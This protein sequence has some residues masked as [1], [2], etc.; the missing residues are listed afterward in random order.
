MAALNEI[1]ALILALMAAALVADFLQV[2][3]WLALVVV[4]LV[5]LGWHFLQVLRLIYWLR[6]PKKNAPPLSIGLWQGINA[7][8]RGWRRRNRKR[9]RKLNRLLDQAEQSFKAIADMTIIV[10]KHASIEWLNEAAASFADTTITASLGQPFEQ[11]FGHYPEL[12]AFFKLGDYREV[13]RVD[14]S[15]GYV[16][17]IEIR[18]ILYGDGK[19]LINAHDVSHLHQLETVRQD[20]VANVSHELRTPLTVLSGYLEAMNESDAFTQSEWKP[21]IETMHSQ[22][23]R[24][25]R[26]VE[27]LLVLAR[28][29]NV[30]TDEDL[31]Q[32]KVIDIEKILEPI[33]IQARHLS[34]SAEHD[35]QARY[36]GSTELVSLATEM[37]VVM[38]NLIFNAVKYTHAGG[39]IQA[40]WVQ[41]PSEFVFEVIDT[42]IG[43][44]AQHIPRLSERF[45]RVDQGRSR[46]SGGTGLGLAIV[47][48]ALNLLGGELEIESE[49]G[50]GSTFRCRFSIE[51]TDGLT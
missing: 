30:D 36:E 33:L 12:T 35:I 42:G 17:I 37:E 18:I 44:P 43:I 23:Y 2:S 22:T 28:L 47:K 20:F 1:M 40:N 19:K 24:L 5:Y 14:A 26:I 46:G 13:L 11:V 25:Q 41:H 48:H 39:T 50:K 8:L 45:Y 29:E 3:V 7:R 16:H 51:T 10:D 38:S 32:R 31:K 21:A 34:G 9:K 4:L 15:N 49:E 6:Q 27:D